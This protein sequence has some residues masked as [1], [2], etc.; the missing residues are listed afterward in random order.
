MA[1]IRT[2]CPGGC[3]RRLELPKLRFFLVL[4]QGIEADRIGLLLGVCSAVEKL[5]SLEQKSV[6]SDPKVLGC[7]ALGLEQALLSSRQP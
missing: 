5:E 1:Q 2:L 7:W 4:G 6:D 3:G